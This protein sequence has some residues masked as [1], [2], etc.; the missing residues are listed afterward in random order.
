MMSAN[1]GVIREHDRLADAVRCLATLGQVATSIAVRNMA[2]AALLVAAAAW[3][4]HESRGAHFRAGCPAEIPA[5]AQRT[6]TTLAEAH[7]VANGL[8]ER[9][10]PR[11]AQTMI[12]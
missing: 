11:M 6:M 2:T 5:L 8:I 1:V 7:D 4:R 10:T 12:A 3:S 9:P